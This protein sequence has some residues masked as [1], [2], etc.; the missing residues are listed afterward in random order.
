ML[1]T[2]VPASVP[3]TVPVTRVTASAPEAWLAGVEPASLSADDA[4]DRAV[5][6]HALH[7]AAASTGGYQVLVVDDDPAHRALVVEALAPPRFEVTAVATGIEAISRLRQQDFDVVL[8]DKR[9]PG[10]DG[11]ALCRH[12]RGDLCRALL[13]LIMVTGAS[14]QEDLRASLA[15][16]ASDFIRKPY[17]LSELEAR[18]NSAAITKRL[19]DQME[20]AE[21]LLFSVARL[22]EAKD[23]C[24]GDH[25][26]RLAR[27]AALF[28]ES[29]AL[30]PVQRIALNNGAV[31]HDIG[32][33]AIP[34]RILMKPGKLSAEEWVIMRQHTTIGADLCSVM[35][36]LQP[37]VPI[38]LHHHERW[39]GS[40]YPHGL[41][42]AE[43]P[44]LARVF[45]LLD[46]YDALTS[47]RPYKPAWSTTEAA[48]I[49][50]EETTR[51]YYDPTLAAA[52]LALLRDRAEAF[53]RIPEQVRPMSELMSRLLP[54]WQPGMT[55]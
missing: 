55:A 3:A 34:D 36:S 35:R 14:S 21:T 5:A 20:R 39:D 33:I 37:T 23:E 8:L 16:G 48:D 44:L 54:W 52:F 53:E 24:T 30:D 41:R 7:V 12:I 6:I 43:I 46:V 2:P 4:K 25:C 10:M 27:Y 13:P 42:G 31:L 51:G 17:A 45:Q 38:I 28:G 32:K 1:E 11:D 9:M 18:V 15:A 50:A 49:I 22:V 19:T 29:L 26:S 47:V 40:G